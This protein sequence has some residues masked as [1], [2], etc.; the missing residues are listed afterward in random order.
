[1]INYSNPVG[2]SAYRQ[3]F[4]REDPEESDVVGISS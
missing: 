3:A 1:M 4:V 2:A